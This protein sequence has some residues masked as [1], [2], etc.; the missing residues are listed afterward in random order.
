[1]SLLYKFAEA[2]KE[3]VNYIESTILMRSFIYKRVFD[4]ISYESNTL[5]TVLARE[6]ETMETY[7]TINYI[8]RDYSSKEVNKCLNMS[9]T[10][11]LD[12]TPHQKLYIDRFCEMW[13]KE[14]YEELAKQESLTNKKM[15]PFLKGKK[16]ESNQSSRNKKINDRKV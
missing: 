4:D 6:E 2:V 7:T 11:Y 13:V 8:L 5:E 9:L 14:K 10:D 1:M 15:E 16:N 12:L 3:P